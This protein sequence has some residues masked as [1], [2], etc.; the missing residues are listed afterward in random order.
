MELR[1][2]IPTADGILA[3]HFLQSQ[4]AA[5]V[6]VKDN[7][8]EGINIHQLPSFDPHEIAEWLENLKVNVLITS[9][10]NSDF[11]S[12]VN[13]TGV[14]VKSGA[15]IGSPESLV[16]KFLNRTLKVQSISRKPD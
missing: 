5:I 3:T 16:K 4:E 8:I 12:A 7:E 15:E 9:G 2:A 13:R 14:N 6:D 10:I 1:F 11:L